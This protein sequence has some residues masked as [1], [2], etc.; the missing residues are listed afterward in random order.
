MNRLTWSSRLALMIGAIVSPLF[1]VLVFAQAAT[2]PGYSLVKV[3]LSLLSLGQGGGVQIANFILCG[4][5]AL[6]GAV[7]LRLALAKHRG[8]I[9]AVILPAIF[10]IG[11]VIAG[12]FHPDPAVGFPAGTA[13]KSSGPGSAHNAV[14]ELGFFL[15]NIALV[16][17]CFVF[18][19]LFQRWSH[20]GWAL[21]ALIS[22]LLGIALVAAGLGTDDFLGT[23]F[24]GVVVYSFLSI[25]SGR[26][27]YLNRTLSDAELT[28][29]G[30]S[31]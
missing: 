6:L 8:G 13:L 16:V 20:R 4:V 14:H 21:Y 3:P 18:A 17:C 12:C 26:L 11:L 25:A 15:V 29:L 28:A 24:G 9:L 30:S 27:A 23:T 22:G 1:F 10:G 19:R 5:F 7:G 31:K 2:R